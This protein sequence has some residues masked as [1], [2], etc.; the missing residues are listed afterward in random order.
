MLCQRLASFLKLFGVETDCRTPFEELFVA[1]AGK[2][3]FS[4]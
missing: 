1:A 2:A 4:D 3:G